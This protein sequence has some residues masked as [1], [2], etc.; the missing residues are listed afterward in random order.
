[1]QSQLAIAAA[2]AEDEDD[3]EVVL[4][5]T[6][7]EAVVSQTLDHLEYRRL[8]KLAAPD[9]LLSMFNTAQHITEYT[10]SVSFA[11]KTNKAKAIHLLRVRG[12]LTDI[13]EGVVNMDLARSDM[14]DLHANLSEAMNIVRSDYAE[15][16]ESEL[17][18]FNSS[19]LFAMATEQAASDRRFFK[20]ERKLRKNA[21]LHKKFMADVLLHVSPTIS[22]ADASRVGLKF[23]V[24]DGYLHMQNQRIL[25]MDS[26][27]LDD[28]FRYAQG[29]A[30]EGK[31]KYVP[32]ET[33]YYSKGGVAY[34]WFV[35]PRVITDLFA[36]LELNAWV[37][38]RSGT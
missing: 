13:Y 34:A 31:N 22:D 38:V 4:N 11:S 10:D 27:Q 12:I 8:P 5:L 1:M 2:L 19:S 18:K 15:T 7:V 6:D 23:R 16:P 20:S 17:T 32:M 29:V 24:V 28:A 3:E 33:I 35:E 30:R 37:C 14:E 21:S 26:I 25:M 9:F 36:M